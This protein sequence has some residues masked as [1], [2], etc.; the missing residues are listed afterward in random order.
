M[1][2]ASSL[3]A[4]YMG[5][6]V[7]RFRVWAPRAREVA[8]HIKAPR[9]R[10]L[11]MQREEN[12]Y[13]SLAA[14][15]VE[16]GT[17]YQYRLDS[18]KERPDPASRSQP[19][20][21]HGPSQVIDLSFNWEDQNWQGLPLQ[22]YIIYEL[23]TGTYTQ[24]G[25]FSA[26]I[27]HLQELRDTGISA[28]ELMP[29]AQFPGTRNW[30]YDG[31]SPFAVQDSYG[32]ARGLQ[33][34][35]NACHKNGLAVVL[36]V[37]YNH[38]GPEG[39]YLRDFA[40]YFTDRYCTPWGEAVNFDGEYSD[41][42]R[43]FFIENA[44][45]WITH[46]HIDVLRLDAIH[47]IM[48]NSPLPFVA[49]LAEAVHDQSRELKRK[50]YVM[51]ES[52][53]NDA[54]LI[55]SGNSDGWDVDAQWSD[56][57]HHALHAALTGEKGGYYEDFA[58]FELLAKTYR[59]GYAYT[60]E[61]APFWKRKRGSPTQGLSGERF[62]VFSQN[63]DQVGNRIFGERLSKLTNFEGL[64]LAAGAVLLSPYIPLLFMGEE[65]GETAPFPYFISHSEAELIQAVREGR[66]A[67][68]VSFNWLQE[69]PDPQDE[70]T[71]KLA[72]LDHSLK[73]NSQHRIL[74]DYYR[75]L[76]RLRKNTPALSN[77][78]RDSMEVNIQNSSVLLVRRWHQGQQIFFILNFGRENALI[79]TSLPGK[80]WLRVMDS[81][82]ENWGGPGSI[83]PQYIQGSIASLS[84]NP[85]TLLV[86]QLGK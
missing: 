82:D 39:N 6:G 60:G 30:G 37:V 56:D 35:V 86:Y 17:P 80:Q 77:L 47:A 42:V 28:I 83:S 59:E 48:D 40:Y 11:A 71:Y 84:I 57:F 44:L 75:E 55:R 69:P 13:F 68:F 73:T 58:S 52:H 85:Q 36:D 81:A 72:R 27:P 8:V 62:V 54:R 74:L 21:V 23:H 7:C 50:V 19:Q 2:S 76:I 53:L 70:A 14:Q 4:N 12:G 43:R 20:G 66:R 41:E 9:E 24:E 49:E 34:L 45:Y 67:E 51:A 38:L 61:Y 1:N 15:G 29:V 18:A 63:H 78:S 46:F 3:G 79:A 64:K 65:Y 32:G 5:N 33:E 16:P 26:I 10:M 25:T 31:V 22:N